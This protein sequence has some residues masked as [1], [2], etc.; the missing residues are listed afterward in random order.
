MHPLQLVVHREQLAT[1]VIGMRQ[2]IQHSQHIFQG[3]LRLDYQTTIRAS[4][5][6]NHSDACNTPI[7][8]TTTKL[9]C[10]RPYH[11][12]NFQTPLRDWTL[13]GGGKRK[14][15]NHES[16][17]SSVDT[18]RQACIPVEGVPPIRKTAPESNVP[19]K[20]PAALAM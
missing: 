16:S 4:G 18:Q 2:T 3:S 8:A 15:L 7:H 13:K 11:K 17:T 5:F 10:M 9:S 20:R 14:L 12:R 6:V 1:D 19:T